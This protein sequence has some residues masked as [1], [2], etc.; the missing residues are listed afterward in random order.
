MGDDKKLAKRYSFVSFNILSD[1]LAGILVG[2]VL[3]LYLDKWLHTKPLFIII[4][5]ILGLLASIR[6]IN[7]KTKK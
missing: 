2:L 1:L 6:M 5:L 3:G 7:Q 4:C